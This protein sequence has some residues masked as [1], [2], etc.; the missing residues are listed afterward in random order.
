M[1]LFPKARPTKAPRRSKSRAAVHT[2]LPSAMEAWPG[3]PLC[4]TC[5]GR[6][7]DSVHAVPEVDE[8]ARAIDNRKLGEAGSD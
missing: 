6:R 1:S 3:E 7:R 2:F 5:D 4:A 8:A